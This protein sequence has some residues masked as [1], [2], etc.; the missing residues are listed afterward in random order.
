[1][2]YFDKKSSWKYLTVNNV[3]ILTENNEIIIIG[4]MIPVV[5]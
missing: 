1:M 4:R 2:K 3:T 5:I